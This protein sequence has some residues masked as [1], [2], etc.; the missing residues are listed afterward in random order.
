MHVINMKSNVRDYTVLFPERADFIKNLAAKSDCVFV[1]DSNVWHLYKDGCLQSLS[2]SNVVVLPASEERK[3]LESVEE[4]YDR[5]MESAAKKNM[6]LVSIG[7]GIIQDITGFAAT[8]LYRGIN[9]IF[10]PTT[11]LAQAD[12]C[13]GSKTS[14][15]YKRFKNLVGTFYPPSEVFIYSPFLTTLQEIDFFSGLGEVVKLHIMGGHETTAE[16]IDLLPRILEREPE[17]LMTCVRKSLWIKQS[18]MEGDEFDL[19]RRNL[20]NFGHCLGHALE[21]V[22]EYAI[23]HGQAVLIG[24]VFANIAAEFRGLLSSKQA[25]FLSRELLLNTIKEKGKLLDYNPDKI[26]DA[27]KKDKKRTG[28]GLVVVLMH[29]DFSF[30]KVIDFSERELEVVLE[31]LRQTLHIN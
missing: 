5:F 28:Q 4:L 31:K 25:D 26:L 9:W 8:T 14:L 22:S 21:T 24:M 16:L 15:N 13:I 29:D 23:P 27:M 20:L 10:L 1:V 2:A 18:Y 19:G 3:N 6:T 12:S 17:A 11:L 30:E 7:G